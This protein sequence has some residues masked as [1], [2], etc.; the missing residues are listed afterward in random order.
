MIRRSELE[1]IIFSTF[2]K[3]MKGNKPIEYPFDK[4]AQRNK[5]QSNAVQEDYVKRIRVL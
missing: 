4:P 5:H 2:A 1:L 3:L